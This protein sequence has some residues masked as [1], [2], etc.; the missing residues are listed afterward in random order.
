MLD[1]IAFL[2]RDGV[3]NVKASEHDYIKKPSEFVFL[4]MAKEAIRLLNQAG[5]KVIVISNQRGI[6]RNLMTIEDLK[7]IHHYMCLS[8]DEVGANIDSIYVCPHDKGCCSCRKPGIGLFLQA[9]KVYLVDK[10]RSWMIG[11]SKSDIEAGIKYGVKTIKIGERCGIEDY[12]CNSLWE[13][14][15]ILIRSDKR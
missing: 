12:V 1:K 10:E 11:D 7:A 3:I 6:A 15:N 8:L 9:E 4:P 13:A 14:A 2:D 5:Y